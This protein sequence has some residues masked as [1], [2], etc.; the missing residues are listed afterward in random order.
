MIPVNDLIP[1]FRTILGWPYASPGS[2]SAQGIDCS[3][4]F[5]YAYNRFNQRIYHGSNRIIRQYCHSVAPAS[6]AAR[7]QPGMAIFKARSDLSRLHAQYKPGGRYYDPAL[8]LDYYHIG[9]IT[10]VQ[11]LEIV[12]ATTPVARIDS[13]LSKWHSVAYLDA[14][15]YDGESAPVCACPCDCGDEQAVPLPFTATVTAASGQ[16]VNLRQSPGKTAPVVARVPL[17]QTVTVTALTD[18]TWWAVTAAN[19]SGY[20]MKAFLRPNL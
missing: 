4:A 17:N 9:L 19:A 13:D 18:D 1:V 15:A 7:L 11:P 6:D 3:G 8:P 16:T 20:M 5:V 12:N 14:V 10:S 2:N